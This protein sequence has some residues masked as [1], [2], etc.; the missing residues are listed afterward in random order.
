VPGGK[1]SGMSGTRHPPPTEMTGPGGGLF[2]MN[3]ARCPAAKP[4][5]VAV[6]DVGESPAA[7]GMVDPVEEAPTPGEAV[8]VV[9]ASLPFSRSFR[10]T[11]D[12]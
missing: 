7:V 11:L 2:G 9:V 3:A 4:G 10:F 5:G 12:K 6:S 8:D 1:L